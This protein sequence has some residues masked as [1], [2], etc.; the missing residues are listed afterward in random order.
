LEANEYSQETIYNYERDLKV[1]DNFLCE[2]KIDFGELDRTSIVEYGSYLTSDGRKTALLTQHGDKGLDARSINRML[3]AIRSYLHYLIDINYPCPLSPDAVKLVRSITKHPR[4][5]GTSDL[6]SLIEAPTS[7]EPDPKVALRN[8]AMLEILFATGIRIS[9]LCNL[10]RNQVDTKGR[11]AIAGKGKKQYF[12]YLTPRARHHLSEYVRTRDDTAAALF[13]PYAGRN[14][15]KLKRRVSTNYLQE[16]IKRYREKLGIDVPISAHSLRLGFATYLAESE[17]SPAPI[18]V[19]F[20][21][22][23]LNAATNYV[24]VPV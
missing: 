5:A 13:I 15:V 14:V 7:L 4:I 10:N 16:R 8:R 2:V 11:I 17:T 6:I 22:E 1:F 3:S 20:G 24:H 21:H 23:C 12:I 19:M 9:E 18:A